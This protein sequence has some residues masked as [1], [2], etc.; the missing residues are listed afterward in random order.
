MWCVC[1]T[2][3]QQK[4]QQSRWRGDLGFPPAP[5]GEHWPMPGGGAYRTR[6]QLL[7]NQRERRE[8]E[9]RGGE[10]K[11]TSAARRVGGSI[12]RLQQFC[13]QRAGDE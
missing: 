8:E 4:R 13:S 11:A 12:G 3:R 6:R 2:F 10:D 7:P 1:L 5:G 9:D